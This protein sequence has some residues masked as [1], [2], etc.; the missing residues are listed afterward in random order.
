MIL[1][2]SNAD[3]ELLA[4]RSAWEDLPAELGDGRWFHADRVDGSPSIE[5]V[6]I[7]VGHGFGPPVTIPASRPRSVTRPSN[8]G[9]PDAPT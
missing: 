6:S 7:V 4:L 1:F 3:T 2:G 9:D 5:G 8:P